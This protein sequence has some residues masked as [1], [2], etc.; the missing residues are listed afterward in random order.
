MQKYSQATHSR[1]ETWKVTCCKTLQQTTFLEWRAKICYLQP[2][3]KVII[4]N[5]WK[6]LTR[7]CGERSE[8]ENDNFSKESCECFW[9]HKLNFRNAWSHLPISCNL[10]LESLF[11]KHQHVL[12]WLWN[13]FGVKHDTPMTEKGEMLFLDRSL[14]SEFPN[15]PRAVERGCGWLP[16]FAQLHIFSLLD[17]LVNIYTFLK[18]RFPSYLLPGLLVWKIKAWPLDRVS[19]NVD[20]TMC[21]LSE[22]ESWQMF[23]FTNSSIHSTNI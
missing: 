2:Q 19:T 14:A 15:K 18:I 23:S 22:E 9:D 20:L 17:Q 12:R 11:V 7:T 16:L 10:K 21:N 4:N 8:E 3:G 6:I 1:S 13:G 5:V